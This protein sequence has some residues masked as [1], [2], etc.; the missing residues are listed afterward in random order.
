MKA[1][2]DSPEYLESQYAIEV[3]FQ[4]ALL[5][6]PDA[7]VR[8]TMYVDAYRDAYAQS[9]ALSPE[10]I[11]F[12]YASAEVDAIAPLLQGKTVI[13][14]GCGYGSSTLHIAQY[15][16]SVT[17]CDILPEVVEGALG[18]LAPISRQSISFQVVRPADLPF[19]LHS[20][21]VIYLSDVIEHFHPADAEAFL[22]QA[23]R[24]LRPGGL[25]VCITPH[26]NY[27]PS[28]I[29]K[30]FVPTGAR[31][32][33]F[34]IQE[35]TYQQLSGLLTQFGFVSHKTVALSPRHMA[36]LP[37]GLQS[38]LIVSP[39]FRIWA[40]SCPSVMQSKSLKRILGLN[41]SVY[42]MAQTPQT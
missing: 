29:S 28:D 11:D 12:G 2:T 3:A 5:A 35:Y 8:E 6:Q 1:K 7:S 41:R 14:Y 20:A 40:E 42:L 39:Q 21:D 37:R 38:A 33:G 23:R 16:K 25:L 30:H 19:P 26:P 15:A 36:H 27:G 31:S 18:R 9:Q 13:D 32:Q 10:E 17:G 22:E 24:V 34:H 4:K